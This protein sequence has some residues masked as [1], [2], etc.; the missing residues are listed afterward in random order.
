MSITVEEVQCKSLL[1][2]IR[3]G[4]FSFDWSLNPYRGCSHACVYCYAR[5]YHALAQLD[6][7]AGF[8]SRIY[9]K[10]NA[11]EVLARELGRG[12]W[13]GAPIAIGTAVDAYQPAEGRYR[14]TRRLLSILLEHR[15][16]CQLVT[17]NSLILRD[18]DLLQQLAQK[19]GC[20]VFFSITTTNAQL[21]RQIEPDTPP[22]EQRLYVMQQLAQAGIPTGVLMAPVL[23]V[24]TDG[25]HN[26]RSVLSAAKA[27]GAA[28]F[29]YAPLRLA[30][31]AKEVFQAFLQRTY[32]ALLPRYEAL[33]ATG[34]APRAYVQSLRLRIRRTAAQ[35]DLPTPPVL[36]PRAPR[37]AMQPLPLAL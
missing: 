18:R 5:E 37:Q 3:G 23:P 33:F 14:L 24:L 15:A 17:K 30:P 11:P 4:R 22:V 34:Y 8:S 36:A 31:G 10:V 16:P 35:I 12:P 13:D 6:P 9:A 32:P 21:A 1:N 27:H 29:A 28:F 25:A 7:G 19:A 20:Q 2:R 26:V